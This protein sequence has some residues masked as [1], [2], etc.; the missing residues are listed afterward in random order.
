M[1]R[2]R[3]DLIRADRHWMGGEQP[4]VSYSTVCLE[5]EAVSETVGPRPDA[6]VPFSLCLLCDL[7]LFHVY[8]IFSPNVNILSL[9]IKPVVLNMI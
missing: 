5:T 1:H 8:F 2:V 9:S 3:A 4:L 6:L 7:S